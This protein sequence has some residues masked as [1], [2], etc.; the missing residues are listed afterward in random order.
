MVRNFIYIYPALFLCLFIYACND[1]GYEIEQRD[2]SEAPKTETKPEIKQDV[3]QPKTDIKQDVIKENRVANK[4]FTIQIGAFSS[5]ANA[6][7]L[8]KRAG[9]SINM[10]ISY[11]FIDGLYKVRAGAFSTKNEAISNIEQILQAGFKDPFI[12]EL[13][14]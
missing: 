14:K 5:E 6:K 1:T 7:D 9:K 4:E 8:V 13:N 10:E 2:E 3:E 12:T 11:F